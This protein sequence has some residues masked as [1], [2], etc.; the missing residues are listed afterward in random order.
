MQDL[1]GLVA[2][3]TGGNGGIGLGMATAMAEAGAGIV[4]WG[5]QADKNE[6]AVEAL[7]ACGHRA[8][9][10][11]CD[12]AHEDE[13]VETFARSVE[14]MGKVDAVFANAGISGGGTSITD[15]TLDEWRRINAVNLDGVFLCLREGARHLVERGEGGSLVAISSTAA[16]HG[17]GRSHAYAASKTGVL[18]LIRA[19][20]VDLARHGIRANAVCPGWTITELA[21]GGYADARFRTA[22]TQRTPVRRWAEPSELGPLAVYL[23]DPSI[24]FH[25]GDTFVIDGGYTIF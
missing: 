3:V 14:A 1:T 18:G 19:L 10:F 16:I 25:T 21:S 17:P 23:A 24:T 8:A 2:L 12:V 7:Q 20:A 22:T 9:A 5:R 4:I 15:V 6:T 13:V 11:T